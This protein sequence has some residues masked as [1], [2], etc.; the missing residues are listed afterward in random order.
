VQDKGRPY[1]VGVGRLHFSYDAFMDD[2]AVFRRPLNRRA[3]ELL[4][5]PKTYGPILVMKTTLIKS[6]PTRYAKSED[7]LCWDRLNEEDLRSDHYK[8]LREEWIRMKGSDDPKI[9][10]ISTA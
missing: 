5:R 4:R 10:E 3:S 8:R 1:G 6:E 2:S 9:L 7:I